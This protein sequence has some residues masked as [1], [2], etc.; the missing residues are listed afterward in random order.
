MKILK[1]ILAFA[2]IL[3]MFGQTTFA[4]PPSALNEA[5]YE[6]ESYKTEILNYKNWKLYITKIDAFIDKINEEKAN[7]LENKLKKI[8]KK[9]L[10]KG[11]WVFSSDKEEKI[12]FIIK[13][14]SAKIQEK[15]LLKIKK[16]L[17]KSTVSEEDTKKINAELI[18]IQN[19]ILN[20]WVDSFEV[21]LWE[22]EN[23]SNFEERG[24]FEFKI[25]ANHKDFWKG[26]I[27]LKL[28]DYVSRKS[29]F[30]S[31]F[32]SKIEAIIESAPKGWEEVK[33]KISAFVDYI[34]KDQN[35]YVLLKNLNITD[36]K[37][38]DKIK[39]FI[40]KAKQLAYKNKY[41]KIEDKK[42]AE[43]FNNLKQLSPQ[44]IL[45]QGKIIASK[46]L[47]KA[48]KKEWNKFYLIPSKY[49]CDTA[50]TLA[51]KFDPFNGSNCTQGQYDDLLKDIADSKVEFYINFSGKNTEIWFEANPNDLEMAEW[52]ISFSDK[53]IEEINFIIKPNQE[54]YPWEWAKLNYKRN[55]FFNIDFYANKWKNTLILKSNLNYK[56]KFNKINFDLKSDK[57]KANLKL[58]NKKITWKYNIEWYKNKTVWIIT[59]KTD[60]INTLSE[61]KISN[62]IISSSEYNPFE[63]LTIFEYKKN[64]FNLENNFSSEGTKSIFKIRGNYSYNSLTSGNIE[65]NIKAKDSEFDYNTYKRIYSWDF[66]DILDSKIE[67]KNRNI[68]GSTKVYV[69]SKEYLNISHKG[70]LEKDLFE[71]NNKIILSEEAITNFEKW[72]N[73]LSKDFNIK[74]IDLN[75]NLKADTRWN[76]NNW[77]FY[78]DVNI[79]TDKILELEI[80][81]KSIKIYK[82]VNITAPSERNTIPLEKAIQ[83]ET[84]Y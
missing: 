66:K 48:Y 29:W 28:K 69:K 10:W 50:K 43:I 72:F 46:P 81:N 20:Y 34:L 54:N 38:N 73:P 67:L 6:I 22:L 57:V 13:Y 26:K 7:K 76:K 32:K 35:Y 37:T 33:M 80:D 3:W 63:N 52:N 75:I 9:I 74:K 62:Q 79:D 4:W 40:E 41:I 78:I 83:N 8:E 60:Y 39:T 36:E 27:E 17:F 31:Q 44:N 16:N 47:F 53:Y 55:N 59:W 11:K 12:Y 14:I 58:E 64:L 49:G 18:K 15:K 68:S 19:N 61:L 1:K 42:T 71:L 84:L 5:K 77:N 70:K 23:I 24:D 2:I 82:K 45:K 51:Q 30:D 25:N 21:I 56:N 65:L